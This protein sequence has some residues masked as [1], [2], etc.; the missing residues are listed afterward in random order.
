MVPHRWFLKAYPDGSVALIFTNDGSFVNISTVCQVPRGYNG[1]GNARSITIRYHKIDSDNGII[2]VSPDGEVWLKL[3]N[4]NFHNLNL[5]DRSEI[6]G[7]LN[8][9]TSRRV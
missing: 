2:H 1:S 8:S 3:T 7:I 4:Q 5:Y 9:G 6:M